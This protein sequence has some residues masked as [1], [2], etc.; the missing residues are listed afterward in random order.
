MRIAAMREWLSSAACLIGAIVMAMTG[1]L[2]GAEAIAEDSGSFR[3]LASFTRDYTTIDHAGGKVI[4]GSAEGA[5]TVVD[6]S[7]EPFRKGAGGLWTC[8]TYS[9]VPDVG[10]PDIR[11]SCTMTDDS[12]DSLFVS[13]ARKS[14]NLKEGGGGVGQFEIRGGTGRYSGISGTC[15][16]LANYLPDNWFVSEVSCTWQ[17]IGD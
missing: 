12:G 11:A 13:T 4:G 16:Y 15:P 1:F 17:R 5:G 6:S 7:G 8:V 2:A 9:K 3:I 10:D 14:G